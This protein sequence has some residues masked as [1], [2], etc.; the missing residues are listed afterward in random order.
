MSCIGTQ[1][2]ASYMVTVGYWGIDYVD[3]INASL[4]SEGGAP[5]DPNSAAELFTQLAG[6]LYGGAD[7][8]TTDSFILENLT[9]DS[10]Q[11]ATC[12]TTIG[13]VAVQLIAG[14][15]GGRVLQLVPYP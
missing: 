1:A 10:C 4:I 14:V 15:D 5:L 13:E 2:D 6:L 7:R 3:S 9:D 12:S 8:D 11:P